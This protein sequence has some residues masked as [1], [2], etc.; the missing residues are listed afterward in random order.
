M[1]Y[2]NRMTFSIICLSTH[3]FPVGLQRKAAMIGFT[4]NGGKSVN[5]S[6]MY[7]LDKINSTTYVQD[8]QQHHYD[9]YN[10]MSSSNRLHKARMNFMKSILLWLQW[11]SFT[12]LAPRV[13]NPLGDD[14]QLAMNA[15]ANPTAPINIEASSRAR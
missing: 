1:M 12:L 13:I 6:V 11:N 7:T 8:M 15:T 10:K 4:E 3:Y 2:E 14:G 9:S 5:N